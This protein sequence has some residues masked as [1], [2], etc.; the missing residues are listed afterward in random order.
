LATV[1]G[2]R[3]AEGWSGALQQDPARA[4]RLLREALARDP[5]RPT[6]YFALGVLRQMQ[7]RLG[8]ARVQFQTAIALD[9]NHARAYF[10]LGETLMYL[11]DPRAAIPDFAQAIRLSPRDPDMVRFY[12]AMGTAHLLLGQADAAIVWLERARAAD[13]RLW[14]PH[15]YLAGAFAL[16]GDMRPAKAELAQSLGLKPEI[17][18]LA[19]MRFYNPWLT[20]LQ[21]WAL[22]EATLN[23]GLRRAGLQD[24]TGG[25]EHAPL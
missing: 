12:W 19:R 25:N 14:F 1:L 24:G 23:I 15:L 20:T 16:R 2:G 17:N 22:Q 7:N 8:E 3:L 9:H 11:G 13:P 4:E 6:A 5:K 21:Y 18:S 10:H